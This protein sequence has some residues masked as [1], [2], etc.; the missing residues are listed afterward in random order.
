LAN[1]CH[2]RKSSED[3]G[4]A[5]EWKTL[6]PPSQITIGGGGSVRR[7]WLVT[8]AIVVSGAILAAL[9]LTTAVRCDPPSGDGA[10]V[11]YGVAPWGMPALFTIM[12]SG[13]GL[14][15]F[16]IVRGDTSKIQ[17]SPDRLKVGRIRPE[18]DFD[19]TTA[20]SLDRRL[21]KQSPDLPEISTASQPHSSVAG[22]D[23]RQMQEDPQAWAEF[24]RRE[25]RL[26]DAYERL[27]AL[28]KQLRSE[29]GGSAVWHSVDVEPWRIWIV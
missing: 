23:A 17:R 16:S 27:A 9:Y 24:L 22:R 1:V 8:G 11:C 3:L 26:L 21:R 28:E 10:Q 12:A 2:G 29:L 6:S 20:D 5:G 7:D 14:M 18:G 15:V 4:I 25:K 19:A 13:V